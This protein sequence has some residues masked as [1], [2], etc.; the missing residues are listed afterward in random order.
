MPQSIMAL[1]N[2]D[3][4]HDHFTMQISNQK[5][6]SLSIGNYASGWHWKPVDNL[7]SELFLFICRATQY[8]EFIAEMNKQ[9]GDTYSIIADMCARTLEDGKAKLYEVAGGN[10]RWYY[11]QG[12]DTGSEEHLQTCMIENGMTQAE[13]EECRAEYIPPRWNYDDYIGIYGSRISQKCSQIVRQADGWTDLR[14]KLDEFAECDDTEYITEYDDALTS[15]AF[16]K[17]LKVIKDR[18]TKSSVIDCKYKN[19]NNKEMTI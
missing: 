7:E 5:I 4:S 9:Y 18:K 1:P 8:D 11:G 15:N 3:I 6:E 13:F 14:R 2:I 17:A 16:A 19:K 12:C 10:Q